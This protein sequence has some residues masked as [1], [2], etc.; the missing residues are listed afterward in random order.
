MTGL[1]MGPRMVMR[2][3][4]NL[5]LTKELKMKIAA[6]VIT[7]RAVCPECG[8]QMDEDEVRAGWLEDPQDFTTQCP[9]CNH[10]FVAALETRNRETGHEASFRYLCQNQLFWAM[11]NLLQLHERSRI[12]QVFLEGT[13]PE[14]FWNLIRHY[15]TYKIGRK[16]YV[17]CAR[18]TSSTSHPECIRRVAF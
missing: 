17:K 13:S 1:S 11:R 12:G 10:R 8:Y 3:S 7:P 18:A 5:T 9:E 14:L 4:L 6:T 15:G 2:Q 16:A